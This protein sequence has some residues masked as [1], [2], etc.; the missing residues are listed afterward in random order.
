MKAILKK[1][2][3]AIII[4]ISLTEVKGVTYYF[5]SVSGNDSRSLVQ[6]TNPSTPWKSI[7]KLNSIMHQLK[8][9]DSVLFKRGETFYG[10]IVLTVSGNAG[11]KIVFGAFGTGP[12]PIIS[13]SSKLTT[14]KSVGN[15][16]YEATHSDFSSDPVNTL[17]FNGKNMEMG[18]FP[19]SND[20]NKGYLNYEAFE[21]NHTI[22]DNEWNAGTNW[23]GAEIVV[24]KNPW[25]TD[26]MIITS[27]S[28]NRI[29]F[30]TT[31]GSSYGMKEGYGYFIQN[32]LR[33]LDQLG[34]WFYDKG[35]KS[36]YVF[37]GNQS[38]ANFNVQ[39]GTKSSVVTNNGRVSDIQFESLEFYGS[40]ANAVSLT[41]AHNISFVNLKIT[42]SGVNGI[43]MEGCNSPIIDGLTITNTNNNSIRLRSVD[44]PIIRNN[45]IIGNYLYPGMGLNGDG[46]G[47][48]IHSSNHN[49]LIENNQI[50]NS[51]YIGINFGGNNTVVKNNLVDT[52]CLTKNDGGGIYTYTGGG[53]TEFYNR[54]VLNNIIINGL[55][56][57]E[58]TSIQSPLSRAQSEGIYLDDNSSGV[59]IAYN[60]IY[61]ISSQGIFFHNARRIHVHNNL[62]YDARYHVSFSNDNMG[63]DIE[64]NI[65]E[66]NLFF[67]KSK[68]EFN[69][70]FGSIADDIKKMARFSNNIYANPFSDNYRISTR[71][72]SGTSQS[73]TTIYDL[74][75]WKQRYDTDH[76]SKNHP[77]EIEQF[78]VESLVGSNRFANEG[79]D[80]NGL[81]ATCNG[82][83]STWEANSPLDQGALRIQG[84][85]SFGT[86][87]SVGKVTAGK[88]YLLT[89]SGMS[90]INQPAKI[91]LRYGGSPWTPISA[92]STVNFDV[93]R[94]EFKVKLDPMVDED[95]ARLLIRF[96][97]APSMSAWYDNV[98]FTEAKITNTD[99]S[100]LVFFEY[101]A[102][103][104]AKTYPLN[105]VYYDM[106]NK[107]YTNQVSI[108]PF[109]SKLLL[110]SGEN[111][112]L[113]EIKLA[114]PVDNDTVEDTK[115]A[116]KVV[117]NGA[118]GWV[119][120][121]N[122][123]NADTLVASSDNAPF[124][125]EWGGLS[126]GTYKLSAQAI[127]GSGDKIS[128]PLVTVNLKR[129]EILPLVDIELVSG[130]VISIGDNVNLKT[131]AFAPDGSIEKVDIFKDGKLVTSLFDEPY[132]FSY[133][134]DLSGEFSLCAKAYNNY[135]LY[136]F[137]DTLSLTIEPAKLIVN[138]P[139][140]KNESLFSLFLNAGSSKLNN[141]Q[142]NEYLGE[143][144]N[145]KFYS[146]SNT[147]SNPRS[148]NVEL[149]QTERNAINL[150]YQIQ[151]P[152]G[153]YKV[154][155]LHNELWFGKA[156]PSQKAG[157]R[158]FDIYV[159]E[160]LKIKNFDLFVHNGNRESLLEFDMI[161]V[162]NNSLDI[163]LI[164]SANRA[165]ISGIAIIQ[166][167]TDNPVQNAFFQMH[168]N[169]GDF[170]EAELN[171]ELFLGDQQ[172][173]GIFTSS[174]VFRNVDA[175]GTPLFQT[176]RNGAKFSYNIP[177][178]NGKYTVVTHHNE[179]W[180]G[181]RGPSARAGRRVFDIAIEGEL[182]EKGL[183]F[184]LKNN[185]QPL[186]LVFEEIIVTDGMLTIDFNATT[187]RASISGL[188]I[189]GVEKKEDFSLFVNT[190]S[191]GSQTLGSNVFEAEQEIG[192][193]FSTKSSTYLNTR[194]CNEPLFH[195]ER[196]GNV[197]EYSIPVPNGVYT[198]HTFH[199]EL[200]F[201]K[202]GPAAREGQRVYDISLE[203]NIVKQNF[204][205]FKESNN[206]S[207]QLTFNRIEVKDGILNLSLQAK[208]NNASICGIAIV[209]ND[210]MNLLEGAN[211]SRGYR[212][213]GSL[214]S[215]EGM[216]YGEGNQV[217]GGSKIY[218]NPARE[219]VTISLNSNEV[220]PDHFYVH[221]IT[222]KL[223]QAINPSTVRQ[224][225]GYQLSVHQL[226]EGMYMVS[227]M[228]KNVVSE[229]FKLLVTN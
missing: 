72:F 21:S 202:G 121:V 94:N 134:S 117:I 109:S 28:S 124:E 151:V 9:G 27:I 55:G 181:K 17:L 195:S 97:G 2:L 159:Q 65:I 47:M 45:K 185:N 14:W 128:S 73:K 204:D 41:S 80:K 38:P 142:G 32:H 40:N 35:K 169:A 127:N 172:M 34:E 176:E 180:F 143:S 115:L 183:D 16:V 77:F 91:F 154:V 175:S 81:N 227:V 173:A 148:S 174:N 30:N 223:M 101:N 36:M 225:N 64:N 50:L 26:R 6:A 146:T 150:N 161:K 137:S 1:I 218:P 210:K 82:C 24:R 99:P 67:S 213:M 118:E 7:E 221:D 19:N 206:H 119:K 105:G 84:S 8:P 98:V 224:Q 31:G 110:K 18:R 229:R 158:V 132:N 199:N 112:P 10:T 59:E 100:Q 12:E 76:G 42:Y 108:A 86:V 20:N 200:W 178:D 70:N 189:Y 153:E 157:Q 95:N 214:S 104:T 131:V 219:F 207:T 48:A 114:S 130:N 147:Y 182:K 192:N 184:F 197:L 96:E 129:P 167:K 198:V 61:N 191:N 194:A 52:F 116:L 92:V 3:F 102:S 78:V 211:L 164:A 15:G 126:N 155:T 56:T 196:F 49:S 87:M 122:Y 203:G 22:I 111:A 209:S 120:R 83:T 156:G 58:G 190:G 66:N 179:L 170:R 141:Y 216:L 165:T 113:P 152:N 163:K 23:I 25:I 13:G 29:R 144:E 63:S 212:E 39:A 88:S 135:G 186:T 138:D 228:T 90:S 33:T 106:E 37:F 136:A 139:I 149:F 43:E 11:S 222:G 93:K 125:M 215:E 69:L 71:V 57:R 75:S 54:K 79:F 205:L 160:E 68:E 171:K 168:I 188:S 208:A 103:K 140:V 201:G 162:T 133:V 85:G 226:P 187:D 62:I 44:S 217:A 74:D 46:N 145:N 89:F 107:P 177:V 166:T 4:L 53:N 51:G 60:T 193:I 123:Y 5:S 220:A